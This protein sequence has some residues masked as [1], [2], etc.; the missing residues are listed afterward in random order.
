VLALSQLNRQVENRHPPKPR[1]ADLRESGAI[2]QDADV[3]AFIYREEVYDE[4]TTRKGIAEIIIAKQRNG[5][6]GNIDLTFLREYTRFENRELTADEPLP[7][8]GRLH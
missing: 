3:I 2:E 4:E 7:S 6:L 5:P 1:L 8:A